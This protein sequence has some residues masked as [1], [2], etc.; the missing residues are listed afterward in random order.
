MAATRSGA[1][2]GYTAADGGNG[3]Y[4]GGLNL[5]VRF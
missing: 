4:G 2:R 1:R 3:T 5:A